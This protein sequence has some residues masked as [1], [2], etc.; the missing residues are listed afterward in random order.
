MDSPKQMHL[1]EVDTIKKW[2]RNKLGCCNKKALAC[3]DNPSSNVCPKVP[4][5]QT[6]FSSGDYKDFLS[7]VYYEND[8]VSL[9]IWPLKMPK[10]FV[11][12]VL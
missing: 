7:N 6:G 10:L 9:K 5:P 2:A 4:L 3:F 11:L 12:N 8:G 1:D